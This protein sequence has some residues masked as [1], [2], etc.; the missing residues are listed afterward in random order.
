ML[1]AGRP[2]DATDRDILFKN[3]R[4]CGVGNVLIGINKYDIPYENGETEENIKNYVKD[5]INKAS[6]ELKDDTLKDVLKKTEPIPLSAEMALLSET[7]LSK[8]EMDETLKF[9]WKRTTSILRR[10]HQQRYVKKPY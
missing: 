2:F 7:P 3:V 4:Q 1:Y 5:E 9:S 8:I 10:R 6:R